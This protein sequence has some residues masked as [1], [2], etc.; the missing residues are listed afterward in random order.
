MGFAV[1]QDRKL[2]T[3]TRE[4]FGVASDWPQLNL[5]VCKIGIVLVWQNVEAIDLMNAGNL[6]IVVNGEM[7]DFNITG[8]L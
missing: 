3:N 7:L 4:G 8:Q 5:L 2:L 1:K 6:N